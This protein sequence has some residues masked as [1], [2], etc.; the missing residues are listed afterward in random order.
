MRVEEW[1]N[2]D[3]VTVRPD[4]SFRTA[5]HLIRQK[6]IRHLLVVEGK[7]LVG[8][9]TDRNLRQSSPSGVGS[10]CIHGLHHIP[11]KL[12][13]RQIMTTRVVSIRPDQTVE[14]AALLLLAHRIGGLPVVQDGELAGLITES[15]I[16]QAFL[17][18]RG[19][20]P[21]DIAKNIV[22]IEEES[23]AP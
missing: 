16:L 4:D 11:E 20:G 21:L 1:M 9:V 5:M 14:D 3:V 23:R 10:L 15:D 12:T 19:K 13:V 17:Q 7:R 8:I 22:A 6:E 18:L 2:R